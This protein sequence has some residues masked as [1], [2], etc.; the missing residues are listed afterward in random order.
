MSPI[1][2]NQWLKVAKAAL[3]AGLSAVIGMLLLFFTDNEVV[4][5][6]VVI[7]PII[8]VILVTA[9]QL[10]TDGEPQG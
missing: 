1:T 3:Y 10:F 5:A 2:K 8:N 7:T 9:K 6:G 4:V